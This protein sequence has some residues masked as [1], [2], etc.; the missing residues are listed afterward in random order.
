MLATSQKVTTTRHLSLN[1]MPQGSV[2][3][4]KDDSGMLTAR[5]S[6]FGFT[7][8]SRH[9]AE[10]VAPGRDKPVATFD[11]LLTADA[12]GKIEQSTMTSGTIGRLPNGSHF[13]IL[14]GS[15]GESPAVEPI[16]E[17]AKLP[18][19]PSGDDPMPL[20]GVDVKSDGWLHGNATLVFNAATHELTVTVDTT[21]LTPGAHA[22][23]I[24]TG[25]CASQGGV[26]YMLMDLQADSRGRVVHQT[27]TL[28]DVPAM[29]AQGTAYLNI[30]QG[31]MNSILAAGQPT[32]AFRPLL[33]GNI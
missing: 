1:P 7:P 13:E 10:I 28:K 27:Q 24:H 29:P 22:A 11:T 2:T 21:G 16:A 4:S 3:F 6:A 20:K 19:R 26:Q 23:H 12:T 33:C 18:D 15:T 5:V 9:A 17:T 31:D 14:L 32:L 8:G 25:S 30:H